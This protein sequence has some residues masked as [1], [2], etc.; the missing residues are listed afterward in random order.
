M[1]K[2]N[3]VYGQV[4]PQKVESFYQQMEKYWNGKNKHL[5]ITSSD[6]RNAGKDVSTVSV[7]LKD[8]PVTKA[9]KIS[10]ALLV[11]CIFMFSEWSVVDMENYAL[12][13]SLA[14]DLY[15]SAAQQ[16]ENLLESP[17]T[18]MAVGGL[19][20]VSAD[21]LASASLVRVGATDASSFLKRK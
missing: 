15:V 17:E 9:G 21:E 7:Q 3:S 20:E 19:T 4:I 11:F 8:I 12:N 1:Q 2:S 16:G 18:G 6:Y 10:R 13:M 5:K 14:M